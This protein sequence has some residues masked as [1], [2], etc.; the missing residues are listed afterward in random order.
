MKNPRLVIITGMSGSGKTVA[1]RA[2]EDL[3]FRCIDNLPI[4]LLPRL[5]ELIDREPST[6]RRRI[7]LVMDTREPSFP[8]HALDIVAELRRYDE[9]LAIVFL[10]TDDHT[11]QRRYAETRRAHPAAG[12][13]SVADGIR[14]ERGLLAKLKEIANWRLDTSKM[15]PH[16]LRRAIQ[17]LFADDS[18]AGAMRIRLIS[19]GFG[20]GIP[21]EADVVIDVRFLPNPFYVEELKLL[22]GEDPKVAQYVLSNQVTQEFLARFIDLLYFF[23]PHYQQERRSYLTI[24]V[25]CTGGRHRSVAIVE[26]LSHKLRAKNIVAQVTHRDLRK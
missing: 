10:D 23:I 4:E 24:A 11:L 18:D 25:G 8:S 15:T 21:L 5:V 2:L 12:K 9:Q 26:E 6:E 22:T 20:A 7:A 14:E 16:Q 1:S 19:F 13:G 17:E 3:G